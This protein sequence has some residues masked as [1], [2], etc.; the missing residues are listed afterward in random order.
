MLRAEVLET[1]DTVLLRHVEPMR[2]TLHGTLRQAHPTFLTHCIGW[3]KNNRTDHPIFYLSTL[4]MKTG[5]ESIE[6]IMRRRRILFAGFVARTENTIT[7]PKYV[8]LR[9]L[10]G[11]AGC[12]GGQEKE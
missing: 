9:E 7:L 3:R 11:R 4:L 10:A 1:I 5:S 8:L 2:G 6:A 12:V